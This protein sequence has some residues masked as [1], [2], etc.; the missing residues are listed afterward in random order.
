MARS[1]HC[2]SIITLNGSITNLSSQEPYQKAGDAGTL[3]LWMRK[4]SWKSEIA[5]P[6]ISKVVPMELNCRTT[7]ILS[8]KR[9][10]VTI[11]LDALTSTV[12]HRSDPITPVKTLKPRKVEKTFFEITNLANY[13]ASLKFQVFVI[14][15]SPSKNVTLLSLCSSQDG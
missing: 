5:G 12:M 6:S 15:E 9:S 1:S 8:C 10:I 3:I 4:G 2:L 7:I 14:L 11:L 13:R